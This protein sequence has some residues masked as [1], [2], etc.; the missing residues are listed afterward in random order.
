MNAAEDDQ[1]VE[2]PVGD[3]DGHRRRLPLTEIVRRAA[4]QF[5][6]LVGREPEGVSGVRRS[7]DGWSALIDVVELDRIPASTSVMATFRVDLDEH[8][9]LVSYE[10][11]RRYHR[12]ATDPL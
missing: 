8:G 2:C 1:P 12:G 6:E 7:E 5:A 4:S 11:L 3:A 9:D 10:R